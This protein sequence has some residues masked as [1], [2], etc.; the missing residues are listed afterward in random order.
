MHLRRTEGGGSAI[1][2]CYEILQKP[3]IKRHVIIPLR[4][5]VDDHGKKGN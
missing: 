1:L 4:Y 2:V 5:H 3:S